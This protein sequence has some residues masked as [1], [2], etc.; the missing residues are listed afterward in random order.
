[1]DLSIR[2]A[3]TLVSSNEEWLWFDLDWLR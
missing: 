2:V 3:R 1:M